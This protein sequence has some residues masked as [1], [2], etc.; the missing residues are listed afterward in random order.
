MR[1]E[2]LQFFRDA[3]S[4]GIETQKEVRKEGLKEN[5]TVVA[6]CMLEMGKYIIEEIVQI[7]VASLNEVKRLQVG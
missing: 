2:Y 5:M 1:G 7:S 4:R 6:L 3:K